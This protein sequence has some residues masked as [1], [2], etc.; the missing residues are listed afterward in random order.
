MLLAPTEVLGTTLRFPLPFR[1]MDALCSNIAY[2][3]H[4]VAIDDGENKERHSNAKSHESDYV[5]KMINFLRDGTWP[6]R[7]LS[8]ESGDPSHY[9]EKNI[10]QL[11]MLLRQCRFELQYCQ[12]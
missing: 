4:C 2:L 5:N 6:R 1:P 7:H 12:R 10:L 8:C 9:L 3:N 11:R